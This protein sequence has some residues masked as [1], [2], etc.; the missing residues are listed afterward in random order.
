MN[1]SYGG[2]CIG[3]RSLILRKKKKK[4]KQIPYQFQVVKKF[5]QLIHEIHF[6]E[7]MTAVG[8]LKFL[9]LQGDI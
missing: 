9:R 2:K 8:L 4:R 5:K 1:D 6:N 7:N 3:L